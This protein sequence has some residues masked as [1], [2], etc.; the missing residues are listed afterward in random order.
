MRHLGSRHLDDVGENY[1][2]TSGA[3]LCLKFLGLQRISI[4]RIAFL[5]DGKAIKYQTRL[6]AARLQELVSRVCSD[7]SYRVDTGKTWIWGWL[8]WICR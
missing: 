4:T 7:V 2:G 8:G 5:G 6:E 1:K 3:L